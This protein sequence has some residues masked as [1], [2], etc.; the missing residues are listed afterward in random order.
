MSPGPRV[1]PICL[2]IWSVVNRVPGAAVLQRP[3]KLGDTSLQKLGDVS[4]VRF[5]DSAISRPSFFTSTAANAFGSAFRSPG[6][7][8][9]PELKVRR[10]RISILFPIPSEAEHT[11][12]VPT[13][14]AGNTCPTSRGN[15]VMT[16]LLLPS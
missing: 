7:G 6:V 12:A 9:A 5:A 4:C 3:L 14:S 2:V 16:N 15:S 8:V 13:G 1:R 11:N 10:A